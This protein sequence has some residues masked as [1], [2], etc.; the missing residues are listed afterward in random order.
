MFLRLINVVCSSDFKWF[1][2]QSISKI[3]TITERKKRKKRLCLIFL[4]GGFCSVAYNLVMSYTQTVPTKVRE[5]VF[6]FLITLD[7]W[8]NQARDRNHTTKPLIKRLTNKNQFYSI[9]WKRFVVSQTNTDWIDSNCVSARS[10][11]QTS[12]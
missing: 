4:L 3:R 9:Q 10:M 8:N 2:G 5:R 12:S 7:F 1:I 6:K 11:C